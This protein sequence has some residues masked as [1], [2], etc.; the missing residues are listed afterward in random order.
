MAILFRLFAWPLKGQILFAHFDYTGERT[1][2]EFKLEP[3]CVYPFSVALDK[4]K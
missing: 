1:K 2:W 3:L 4:E